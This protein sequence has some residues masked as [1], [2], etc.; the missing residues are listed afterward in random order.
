LQDR[1]LLAGERKR[2]EQALAEKAALLE[3]LAFLAPP[4]TLRHLGAAMLDFRARLC[5]IDYAQRFTTG[6]GDDRAKLDALMGG[7][8]M[9]A[10]AGACV[11]LISS[12]ARQKSNGGSSTY[13][14]L[15]LASFRGSSELEF[16][17]DAAYLLDAN[18]NAGVA[19]LRC[20]KNRFG[21][22]RD[23]HLRFDGARQAFTAGDPLDSFEAAP[24]KP[25]RK[26]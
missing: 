20:E 2:V 4:F 10:A 15:N 24:D 25:E 17:A 16:G 14:G 9:L 11:L 23:I 1:E 8:R 22:V 21:E 19:A 13:A 3:R 18:L 12:V 6:D 26:K 5:V 7:V